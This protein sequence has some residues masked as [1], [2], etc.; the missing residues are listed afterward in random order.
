MRYRAQIMIKGCLQEFGMNFWETYAS[1]VSFEAL[2]LVLLL[3]LHYNLLCEHIDFVI[4]F[5]NGPIGD[6]VEIY[7]KTPDYFNDNTGRVCKLLR[8]LYDLKQAPLIWYTRLPETC[9]SV[10]SRARR[11][12]M[13]CIGEP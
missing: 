6:D 3:A 2:K 1:V 7:M 9:I 12:T 13:A 4:V 10:A 11:W 5:L 8:S